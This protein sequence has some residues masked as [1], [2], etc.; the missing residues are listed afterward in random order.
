MECKAAVR[1]VDHQTVSVQVP[2]RKRFLKE[3]EDTATM[4]TTLSLGHAR[5]HKSGKL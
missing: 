1:V 5:V 3:P 4:H 2:W